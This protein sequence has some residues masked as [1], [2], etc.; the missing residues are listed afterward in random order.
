M[1]HCKLP[2]RPCAESQVDY[3]IGNE[4]ILVPTS[5][6]PRTIPLFMKGC[7]WGDA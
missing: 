5:W 2:D 1:M 3:L 6:M 7:A 4:V